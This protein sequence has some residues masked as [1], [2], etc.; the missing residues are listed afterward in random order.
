MDVR[1]KEIQAMKEIVDVCV[2]IPLFTFEM[3]KN[4]PRPQG[5]YAAIKCISSVNP[6]FDE[7]KIVEQNGVDMFRTRGVRILTFQVLF[8]REGDEYIKFDNSFYRPDVLQKLREVGFATMGKQPL[9]L[10]T[11][12]LETNWEVRQAVKIQFNVMRQDFSPVGVM[13]GANVAGKFID[14]DNV[15]EIQ[16]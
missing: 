9:D 15:V 6:S 8:S 16:G 7:T 10:A 5:E 2:G 13:S 1:E 4:A 12:A 11:V 14:G 3:Q